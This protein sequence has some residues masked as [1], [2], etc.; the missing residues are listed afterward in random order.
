M[1][2]P[3]GK[4]PVIIL[5]VPAAVLVAPDRLLMVNKPVLGQKSLRLDLAL[6][7]SCVAQWSSPA[8]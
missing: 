6:V 3:A 7:G 8:A 4:R 1:T 2:Q 5:W